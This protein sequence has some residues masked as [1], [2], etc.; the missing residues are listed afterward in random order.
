MD[1][2]EIIRIASELFQG[3][4]DKE[5][6]GLDFEDIQSAITSLLAND[7]GNLDISSLLSNM[8]MGSLIGIASSWLGD[9][10]NESISTSQL[11]EL[12]DDDKLSHFASQLGVD[13][14]S[15]LNGL[16]EA[17]PALVDKAS[18]GGSLL[19]SL[20]GMDG[21]MSMAGKLFGR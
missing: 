4:L 2:S 9:G 5:G 21:V 16:T 15:A 18:S 7:D 11:S 13:K 14:D 3:K 8:N 10:N 20:G 19:D 1:Q 12:L 17:I 6:D